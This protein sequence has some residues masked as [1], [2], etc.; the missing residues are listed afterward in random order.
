MVTDLFLIRLIL[1]NR[2]YHLERYFGARSV[3]PVVRQKAK[4]AAAGVAH[5]LI[6]PYHDG[7]RIKTIYSYLVLASVINS[8]RRLWVY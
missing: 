1:S 6:P 3:P 8:R 4:G 5:V 2:L 7:D